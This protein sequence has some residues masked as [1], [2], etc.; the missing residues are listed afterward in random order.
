MRY[1]DRVNRLELSQT[2]AVM[3]KAQ[4]LK[5]AGTDVIDFGPGEPD[6][7][8]PEAAGQ[9]AVAAIKEGFTRYTAVAGV[10]PLREAIAAH[11]NKKTGSRLSASNVI[12]TCGAKQA[13]HNL[14][15]ALFQEGDQV[16]I[17]R[18]YWVTFPEAVRLSGAEARW[19]DTD[20]D[21]GFVPRLDT[22][23]SGVNP[24]ARGLIVNYPNN[25][26]GAVLQE[27]GIRDIA[28]LAAD[29]GIFLISD[30]TY[31]SFN[32]T[33]DPAGG[34]SFLGA[35][36]SGLEGLAVVGSFSKTYS[37][38]GWRIGYAVGSRELIAKLAALQSHQTGNPASISQKAALAV[39]DENP[40]FL[41]HR[42][43]EYRKRRD[44]I[45]DGLDDL[46]G[47]RC[48]R[49]EGAF[50]VFPDV[51]GLLEASGCRNSIEL[52]E[53]LLSEARIAVV[54][55]AAFGFEGHLRFSYATSTETI[56]KGLERLRKF[57]RSVG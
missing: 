47:I 48:P 18:P 28:G 29:T 9:A 13:I 5:E 49:P 1:S 19:V 41:E 17:P 14:C 50:Y 11:L 51:S 27:S 20:M 31:D 40:E 22:L 6:F 12:V 2:A 34:N 39:L 24:A 54:P 56:E 10:R 26:T 42:I 57:C 16:L 7:A 55:G 25:P 23:K 38:T 33:G 21:S 46:P 15:A 30:E 3:Q 44:L 52:A 53:E 8:T 35:W 43:N 32:F 4:A 36:D 45:A 37:M